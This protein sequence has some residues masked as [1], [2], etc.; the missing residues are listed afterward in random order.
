MQMPS[1]EVEGFL[2]SNCRSS[3]LVF[4]ISLFATLAA[5]ASLLSRSLS[6]VGTDSGHHR[7]LQSS[8]YATEACSG[9]RR[10]W[11]LSPFLGSSCAISAGVV[12]VASSLPKPSSTFLRARASSRRPASPVLLRK[13]VMPPRLRTSPVR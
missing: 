8:L 7:L 13:S 11:L 2:C 6:T 10:H 12:V 3:L 5:T 4:P 1:D 9:A